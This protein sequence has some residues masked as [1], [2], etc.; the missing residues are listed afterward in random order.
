MLDRVPV[1]GDIIYRKPS[2][3]GGAWRLTAGKPYVVKKVRLWVSHKGYY[4]ISIINDNGTVFNF[5]EE[6]F[7]RWY[8]GEKVTNNLFEG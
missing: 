4:M 3:C 2:W 5:G 1:V 7:H 8:F 6:V